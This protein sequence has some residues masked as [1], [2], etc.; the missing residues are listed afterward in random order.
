MAVQSNIM[1][2]ESFPFDSKDDGYDADG[3][4]VYDRAVG[5][6][7][8]RE[9]FS[10]FFTDGAF[11]SPAS[12]LAISPAE[13]GLAVSIAPGAFIIKGAIGAVVGDSLTVQLDEKPPA[14]NTAY[15]VMVRYDENDTENT[16]RSLSIRIVRGDA[17]STALPPSPDQ[18]TPGIYEY[19][20]GYA[21]VPSGA[22]DM[23]G[24][25]VVNEK[26]SAVCPYAAPFVDLD[27]ESVV[28]DAE[29]QAQ[30]VVDAFAVYAQQYY[31]LVASAIDGT[32]A[33]ELMQLIQNISPAGMVDNVTTG[34]TADAKIQVKDRGVTDQKIEVYAIHQEHLDNFLRQKL[35]LLDTSDWDFDDY[36]DYI[37]SLDSSARDEFVQQNITSGMVATW[38]ASQVVQMEGLLSDTGGKYLLDMVDI[39]ARSWLDVKTIANGVRTYSISGWVGRDKTASVTGYGSVPMRIVGVATQ[40]KAGGTDKAALM[41][42]AQKECGHYNLEGQDGSKDYSTSGYKSYVENTVMSAMPADLQQCM[43]EVKRTYHYRNEGQPVS[44]KPSSYA[45]EYTAKIFPLAAYDIAPIGSLYPAP[46]FSGSRFGSIT[47][48]GPQNQYFSGIN[49]L[50]VNASTAWPQAQT[51]NTKVNIGN[52]NTGCATYLSDVDAA[53]HVLMILSRSTVASGQG[54]FNITSAFNAGYDQNACQVNPAFCI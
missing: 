28:F 34:L 12:G 27:L 14:G 11:P 30:D 18:S 20:L 23:S 5:A 38:S 6:S 17:S 29:R 7:M 45:T 40:T 49:Q 52:G 37:E 48:P 16:G 39:Q 46:T 3:Y 31:D 22:S 8:L 51:Q 15:G 44:G 54:I 35:G 19:R 1:R 50:Y 4:P 26:G 25:S 36:V 32:T 2:I 9:A 47:G 53:G 41:F 43:E 21:V 42:W 24:A 10:K 13:D 33:G